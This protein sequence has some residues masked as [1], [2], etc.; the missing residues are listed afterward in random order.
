MRYIGKWIK[1]YYEPGLARLGVE[2]KKPDLLLT[3]D[4]LI[5]LYRAHIRVS[6]YFVTEGDIF[7][8]IIRFVI[9]IAR[10]VLD[11]QTQKRLA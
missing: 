2:A 6:P 9:E 1:T 7:S 11:L 10:R 5:M 8:T 3:L 4:P